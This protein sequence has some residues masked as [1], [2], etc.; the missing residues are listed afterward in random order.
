MRAWHNHMFYVTQQTEGTSI[1]LQYILS[2]YCL[3]FIYISYCYLQIQYIDTINVPFFILQQL[4]KLSC[5]DITVL[6]V[7]LYEFYINFN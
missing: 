2:H 5:I 3:L 6:Y 1:G 7:A 4:L